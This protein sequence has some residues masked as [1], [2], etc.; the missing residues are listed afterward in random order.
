MDR[1]RKKWREIDRKREKEIEIG[2][3]TDRWMDLLI[4]ESA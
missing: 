2:R 1:E 3:Q 4:I